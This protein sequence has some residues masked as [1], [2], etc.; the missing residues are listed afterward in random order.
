[1]PKPG[2]ISRPALWS[3]LPPDVQRF[4]QEH[5]DSRL[6]EKER[7]Q[8]KQAEGQWPRLPRRLWQFSQKYPVLPPLPIPYKVV[9][10]YDD[11]PLS[12][13][14]DL[15]RATLERRKAPAE[16][17]RLEGHWPDYAL[18][19]VVAAK[20]TRV[21][22]LGASRPAGFSP[23]IEEF[24]HGTLFKKLDE[25]ERTELKQLE[26]Q[27]PAYPRQ[28]HRLARKYRLIIP[29][30]S[31]PGSREMWENALAFLPPV[32]G[33]LLRDFYYQ[34]T[35]QEQAALQL[36]ETDPIASR[37]RIKLEYYKK[38]PDRLPRGTPVNVLLKSVP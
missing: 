11:L 36:S 25:K 18:A 1:M 21:E 20:G 9:R 26:G 37:E 7:E 3:E 22:P 10:R 28:L 30:M 32:P 5:L 24:L 17:N 15:T 2:P 13:Q 35:P 14:Q 6:T 31:I 12:V 23:A 34:M 38:Y 8:L 4:Y 27:W 29:G 16:W 19:V 33:H